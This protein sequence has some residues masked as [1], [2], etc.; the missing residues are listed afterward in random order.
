MRIPSITHP[1]NNLKQG[2]KRSAID[3]F[4]ASLFWFLLA[5]IQIQEEDPVV[6]EKSKDDLLIYV[7]SGI[8]AAWGLAWIVGLLHITK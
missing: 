4:C 6:T 7:L 2:G 8:A 5:V 1:C 3:A